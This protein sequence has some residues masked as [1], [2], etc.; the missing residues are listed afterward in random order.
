VICDRDFS[1]VASGNRQ[2]ILAVLTCLRRL[3]YHIVAV[4]T[5]KSASRLAPVTEEVVPV[6]TRGFIG[7][8]VRDFDPALFLEAVRRIAAGRRL[9]VAIAQY[10][11]LAP[12]LNVLPPACLRVVDTHDLLQERA[13]SFLRIGENP[14][15]LCDEATERKL[16]SNADVVI[17]IQE[18]EAAAFRDMLGGGQRVVCVPHAVRLGASAVLAPSTGTS[19]VFVGSAHNG[20]LGVLR[21]IRECWPYVQ[22]RIPSSQ[23]DIYG[24]IGE[25]L[26]RSSSYTLH[27]SVDDLGVAYA[28]ATLTICPIEA[29]S[30]LKI[31]LVEAFCY[32][33]TTVTTRQG[34]AGLPP[35][36]RDAWCTADLSEFGPAVV[37]LLA[38]TEKRHVLEAG[39]MSYGHERF[40]EQAMLCALHE[41]LS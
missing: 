17:A 15:V 24:G 37:D 11:W 3:G 36:P 1:N 14:W 2:R 8:D 35:A 34:A 25:W 26:P 38:N 41:A 16:L 4:C 13:A 6:D 32:R 28:R 40:G 30:G 5:S 31:K 21:F 20:N 19:V 10:A 23:L 7:G 12:C 39:A 18:Q 33:R 9:D 22:Q 27:G 29:G